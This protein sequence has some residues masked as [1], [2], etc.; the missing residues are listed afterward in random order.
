[1]RRTV[2]TL[3]LASAITAAPADSPRSFPSA[4]EV[5]RRAADIKPAAAELNWQRIPWLTSLVEAERRARAE[6]RPLLFWNVDDD[7]LERC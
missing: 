1:M 2:V 6:K 4:E 7:P 5:A 3:I